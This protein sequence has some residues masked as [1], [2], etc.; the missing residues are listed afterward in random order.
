MFAD[1]PRLTVSPADPDR[2]NENTDPGR[3]LDGERAGLADQ[4]GIEGLDAGQARFECDDPRE[5]VSWRGHWPWR[6]C[7]PG[8]RARRRASASG[9]SR[10]DEQGRE[11][12]TGRRE[13]LHW[14]KDDGDAFAV[15]AGARL[16]ILENPFVLPSKVVVALM[17][18]E[19]D[20]RAEPDLL[21]LE[22]RPTAASAA[23]MPMEKITNMT[24]WSASGLELGRTFPASQ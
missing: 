8:I 6:K 1:A 9:H 7:R 16:S 24:P 15:P 20:G 23:A 4:P 19:A 22:A 17:D 12:E 21:T 14:R 11:Q 13:S 2:Y 5:R 3:R 10:R 18:R